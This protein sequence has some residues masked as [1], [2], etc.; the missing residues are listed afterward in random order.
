MVPV[1]TPLTFVGAGCV[2]VFPLSGVA[3]STTNF[4]GIGLP[5]PSSAVTVIVDG[6]SPL[7]AGIVPGAALTVVFVALTPPGR[8][9]ARKFTGLATPVA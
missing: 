3:A 2:T 8:A 9:V 5:N 1:A 7:E 4:P 6:L